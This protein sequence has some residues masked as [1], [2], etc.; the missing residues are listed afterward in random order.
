MTTKT[1][2]VLSDDNST[3][4]PLG[5][6][7]ILPENSI[8]V[9]AEHNNTVTIKP[10]GLFA[11]K[12]A[13]MDVANH[14][15]TLSGNGDSS[16]PLS[17]RISNLDGNTIIVRQFADNSGGLYLWENECISSVMHNNSMNGTGGSDDKLGVRISSNTDNN[18]QLID[19][20]VS[21][22]GGLYTTQKKEDIKFAYT[23]S[24]ILCEGADDL[25]ASPACGKLGNGVY[26][27]KKVTLSKAKYGDNDILVYPQLSSLP[28]KSDGTPVP[29]QLL[30]NYPL[31][32]PG[33]TPYVYLFLI[34][35]EI[36][37]HVISRSA[38]SISKI[39]RGAAISA[40]TGLD[41]IYTSAN[42]GHGPYYMLRYMYNA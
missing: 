7:N 37:T 33:E 20:A 41:D 11:T 25:S 32:Q 29:Y 2:V 18:L 27:K 14:D 3:H 26:W 24:S 4:L 19:N 9:S 34:C 8:P 36:P 40:P 28:C 15:Y 35:T 12:P 31:I 1:P 22:G 23:S 17:V 5:H 39:Y 6:G 38:R 16:N 30:I 21:G 42:P 10:D 13:G